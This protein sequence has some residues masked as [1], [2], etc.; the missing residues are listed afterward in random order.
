MHSRRITPASRH[1]ILVEGIH[2]HTTPQRRCG[3]FRA[4]LLLLLFASQITFAAQFAGRHVSDVLDE[5][6]NEGLT[7]IYNTGIVADD[8]V[9]ATEPRAT[10]GMAL[11]REILQAHGL[12]LSQVAPRTYAVIRGTP[13]TATPARGARAGATAPAARSAIEEVVVQTSRYT[14]A[15]E[16]SG[17]HAFLD[18]VQVAN[19]PR[20]GDE[21]LQAVQRLPGAAVNGFSSVGPIRGGVPNE[22]AILLD[23]LRLYEP[24]HLKNYMSP[25]SLLDSRLIDGLDVYFG[26]FPVNYGDRM[27]AVIDARSI[28]PSLPRYYELGL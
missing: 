15:S 8:L 19:L 17:S 22:T 11:A 13:A 20:L 14:V 10:S 25:V 5:L 24:F 4:A 1:P 21:T 28:R 26:G 16:V 27:S 7:F 9:I 23:G 2:I 18:Q 12:A 3:V 6:R